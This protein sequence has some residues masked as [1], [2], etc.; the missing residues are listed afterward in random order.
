LQVIFADLVYVVIFQGGIYQMKCLHCPLKH[1]G[2]TGKTFHTRYKEHTRIQAIRN[3]NSNSG[4]SN[5]ILNAGHK[6]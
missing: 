2:Q 5:H 3:C 6:Y 4:Y 1:I